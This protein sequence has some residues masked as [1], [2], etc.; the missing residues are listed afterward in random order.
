[1][2]GQEVVEVDAGGK[3]VVLMQGADVDR[4]AAI[5]GGDEA[6]RLGVEHDGRVPDGRV[7][8]DAALEAARPVGRLADLAEQVD[9]GRGLEAQGTHHGRDLGRHFRDHGDDEGPAGLEADELADGRSQPVVA[10]WGG[11]HPD[12][13]LR[14]R[15]EDDRAELLADAG[16]LW[17]QGR[18]VALENDRQSYRLLLANA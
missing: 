12:P 6:E 10:A 3:R 5:G 17:L 14:A 7:F 16:N 11:F 8:G 13:R 4:R 2:L 9:H 1:M 18:T 15:D